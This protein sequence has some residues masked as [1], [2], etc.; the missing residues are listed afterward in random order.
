MAGTGFDVQSGDPAQIGGQTA[1]ALDTHQHPALHRPYQPRMERRPPP[2][3]SR[4]GKSRSPL[5]GR[6]LKTA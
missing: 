2:A 3:H 6:T 1:E 4:P 5:P